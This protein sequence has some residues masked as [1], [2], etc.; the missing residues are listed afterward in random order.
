MPTRG[1]CTDHF[2]I[3]RQLIMRQVEIL[4][5]YHICICV[6]IFLAGA[7]RP[8]Y[9]W[10][11]GEYLGKQFAFVYWTFLDHFEMDRRY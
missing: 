4:L 8:I 10:D 7:M 5:A 6:V 3:T 2:T 9:D 11:T 1:D